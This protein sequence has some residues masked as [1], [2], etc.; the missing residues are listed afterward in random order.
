MVNAG[1]RLRSYYIEARM[2]TSRRSVPMAPRMI[3]T[4][5][6]HFPLYFSGFLLIC[7]RPKIPRISATGA[8]NKSHE[9]REV[10]NE[11]RARLLVFFKAGWVFKLKAD[12]CCAGA[13]C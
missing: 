5:A 1:N 11:A 4:T 2:T 7:E 3:P 8:G 12:A 13:V 10:T 6:I 9:K